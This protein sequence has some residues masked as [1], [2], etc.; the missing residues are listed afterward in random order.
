MILL[1]FIMI[2]LT[3]VEEVGERI[4][5]VP[6]YI[7]P[8]VSLFHAVAA[9]CNEEVEIALGEVGSVGESLAVVLES[10]HEILH[11]VVSEILIA[12]SRKHEVFSL[13]EA[14][15]V[16]S[17]LNTACTQPAVSGKRHIVGADVQIVYEH[18]PS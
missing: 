7:S 18:I 2:L 5:D 9:A 1:L 13:A 15:F 3:F 14:G 6:P 17:V 11:V 12:G 4:H 10:G 8:P 16:D